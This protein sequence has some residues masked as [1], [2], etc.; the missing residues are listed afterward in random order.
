MNLSRLSLLLVVFIDVMGFGLIVPIFN[1]ILLDPQQTFLSHGTPTNIRQLDYTILIVVF[2]VFYFFGAAFIAKLSDYIGRKNGILICL[3]G[4]LI[5]YAL[6]VVAIMSSSYWLLLIGRAI[7]GFTT[8]NQ[9]IAQAALIDISHDEQEKSKNLGMIV[10]AAALGLLGGPLISGL[11]SD[12]NLMGSA[13][14]LELPFYVAIGLILINM[15]LVIFFF[16]EPDFKK[17]KIDFGP[18]DVVSNLWK[19]KSNPVVLRLS[20]VMLFSLMCLNAFF[21]FIDTYLLTRF[22]FGTL[23]NSLALAVFGGSMAFGSAYL[24][25]PL[26]ERF[27][28]FRILYISIAAMGIGIL[29][30]MLNPVAD[31]SY[32]LIVPITIAFAIMYPTMLSL[33]SGSVGPTE[34]GWVMGVT[35]AIYAFG[36]G[37]I[38]ALSG[39]LLAINLRMPFMIAI[40]CC[41]LALIS[42]A[43]LFRHP[44]VQALDTKGK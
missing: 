5:G 13:A 26:H 9:P 10:A 2:F 16:F 6:T 32:I 25:A 33:F 29:V 15:I 7:S 44:G 1:T 40:I 3:A 28:K 43:K 22:D 21:F 17:Q 18:M 37:S 11:L 19:V 30:F 23:Q 41:I 42:M 27:K 20:V 12:Q 36:S 14:S 34:Q 38:T 35:V 4:D 39:S 8:A 24:T 31:L